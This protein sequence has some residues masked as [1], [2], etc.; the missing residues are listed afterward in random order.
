MLP[1]MR[2]VVSLTFPLAL[3]ASLLALPLGPASAAEVNAGYQPFLSYAPFFIAIDN[4]YFTEAGLTVKAERFISAQKMMAPA[5]TGQLDVLGGAV[6][7]GFFNAFA[8]GLDMK[9]V[10]DKGKLSKGN[11]YLLL[12]VRKDLYDSGEV[13]SV[14]DLAGRTIYNNAP[15]TS[16][17]YLLYHILTSNG[18]PY[19][20]NKVKYMDIPKMVQ[21]MQTKAVDAGIFV[22]PWG[23]RAEEMGVGKILVTG[24]QTPGTL[25]FTS[26]FF[27][28]TGKFIRERRDDAQKWM[29]AYQ[30]GVK[31]YIDKGKQSDEV[32]TVMNKWTKLEPDLIKK[33][34]HAGFTYDSM[35][36]IKSVMAMQEWL[37]KTGNVQKMVPE[38]QLFDLSFLKAAGKK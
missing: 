35:P 22:D 6:S 19:D 18:V 5:A 3:L 36:N 12:A 23:T 37:V 27:I 26:A 29:N 4:G 32:A 10:A 13:R 14:K 34:I 9:I 15:F 7:A 21:G 17:E 8:T 31:F 20:H 1:R 38:D 2:R 11:G 30:K 25:D 28:Y 24:D 16:G 33:S